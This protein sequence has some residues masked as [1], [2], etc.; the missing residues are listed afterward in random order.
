[1]YTFTCLKLQKAFLPEKHD[2][3]AEGA[4]MP[5]PKVTPGSLN[6]YTN[7]SNYPDPD[8]YRDEL[9]RNADDEMIMI[10]MISLRAFPCVYFLLFS[11]V[12]K[13]FP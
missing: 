7:I 9:F 5:G 10:F 3:I 12:K 6:S 2:K 8:G 11:A 4:V 13:S 1:M